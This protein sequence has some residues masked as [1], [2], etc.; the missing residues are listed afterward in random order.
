MLIGN[1]SSSFGMCTFSGGASG[2]IE[3]TT[4]ATIP[5]LDP[6]GY[7]E[8]APETSNNWFTGK[9]YGNSL[10]LK[11][12]SNNYILTTSK[13]TTYDLD[14]IDPLVES[15]K[16]YFDNI[17]HMQPTR[18]VTLNSAGDS[19]MTR[20][21]Y[22]RDFLNN[23][24][25]GVDYLRGAN[26]LWNPVEEVTAVKKAG[27]FQL[28]SADKKFF[29]I[30]NGLVLN[31][32]TYRLN[33]RAKLSPLSSYSENDSRFVME[34]D[35]KNYDEMGNITL[36]NNVEGPKNAIVWGYNQQYPIAEIV[37]CSNLD[38]IA[39]ANFES[40]NFQIYKG[41]WN[42]TGLPLFDNSSPGK[43]RVYP[44]SSGSINKIFN[45]P[46]KKYILG[47]WYKQGSV[48]IVS[49]G[50]VSLEQ[51]KN[52]KNNW[53]Y[54]EREITSS[55]SII[56]SGNGFIDEIRLHPLGSSM[57]TYSYSPSIG[58]K[59]VQDN[60]GSSISYEYDPEQRIKYIRD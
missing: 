41:N 39:F 40:E 12:L 30:S 19:L 57:S 55:Q 29:N 20:L 59:R 33:T 36:Y 42:Y 47:Y 43:D 48:I 60:R 11:S 8:I 50:I 32:S 4:V 52:T 23:T 16:Y 51:I 44:L 2:V 5:N 13:I 3:C 37:N 28:L 9:Y 14:G 18:I 25:S 6:S 1:Y 45:Q 56:I 35:Y 54:A 53:I 22:P 7:R 15:K 31:S 10:D 38:D 49:G 46:G 27:V 34:I 21:K 17:N 26:I 24:I 58:L